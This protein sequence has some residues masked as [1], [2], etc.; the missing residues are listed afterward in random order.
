[1]DVA[2]QT[3]VVVG[4]AASGRAAAELAA[5]RGA[6]VLGLDLNPDTQPIDGVE[7]VLGPHP[8][9]VFQ[10]AD[11]IV[12]SPG[13][14]A[15][16][17]APVRAAIGAG[18]PVLGELAFAWSFLHEPVTVG[19]TGTNGKSTVTSFVGQL[20]AA[21]GIEC[22]VGGNLGRPLSESVLAGEAPAVHVLEIS[23]YQLELPG[24]LRCNVAA[25]LNLSPD[26]LARH[27]DMPGYA[28]AKA[29]IFERQQPSDVALLPRDER[30]VQAAH[31]VGQG[32]RLWLDDLPDIDAGALR[33][34]GRH[35]Q[36]NAT[37][38]LTLASLASQLPT[39]Q[40]APRLAGLRALEHRMEP[41]DTPDGRV[42]INDS[43]A[44]NLDAAATGI[45]G[46]ERPA[47]VLLGGQSKEGTD[48]GE[49]APSLRRH[50][51]V[52]TFGAAGQMIRD[53][54]AAAGLSATRYPSMADAVRAAR[55][56]ARQGD[57]VLLSPGCA[58]FD[59]FDD[60]EHR[61]RVFRELALET[62]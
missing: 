53:Q 47:V 45:G 2:G 61:G 21:S 5:S 4:L 1:M 23:S 39:A 20:L 16:M 42:W 28:A 44:T 58:S 8:D 57:A 60:F 13:V 10:Q 41:I 62:P 15:L 54:L 17:L 36:R 38:A 59:E 26:H 11:L 43:K 25:I 46:L 48:Y 7:L 9:K 3:V 30:L 50:R 19:I 33:V 49:L 31:G 27:G 34:P 12:A 55:A 52:L 6:R 32:R 37:V 18:T 29:R 56:L 24:R 22:F 40:L 35:N 14:P 51:A